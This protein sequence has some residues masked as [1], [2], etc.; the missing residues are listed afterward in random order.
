MKYYKMYMNRQH[1][2]DALHRRLLELKPPAAAPARRRRWPQAAVLAACCVLVMGVGVWRLLPVGEEIPPNAVQSPAPSTPISG[3]ENAADFHG[4]V[5]DSG[6]KVD[7]SMFVAIPAIA[8]PEASSEWDTARDI[9]APEGS[10][11][12]DLTEEDIS[13]ILWNGTVPEGAGNVPWMLFWDGYTISGR[14]WYDG[15]GALWQV[16]LWGTEG[17]NGSFS[18]ALAPETLPPT[19]TVYEGEETTEV[20]GVEVSGWSKRYDRDGDGAAETVYESAFLN[21][22]VGVRASFVSREDSLMSDLFIRWALSGDGGLSIEHLMTAEDVPDF[23]SADFASLEAARQETA[24]APYLPQEDFDG[25]MEFYGH[26]TYQEGIQHQ[27]YARWSWWDLREVSLWVNRPEG[28]GVPKDAVVD[29]RDAAAYDV[30]RYEYP[31]ADTVP[32]R[33]WDTMDCPA[34]RAEDMSRE[35]VAARKQASDTSGSRFVFQV[36]YPDG[37]WVEYRCN[38]LTVEEMWALVAET[39]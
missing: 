20:N 5:A 11:T 30:R 13:R 37:T 4:F 34:F 36:V 18:I 6:R 7:A 33:Y 17:K 27:L 31:W 24:F 29:V 2:S 25:Y 32:E 10:F 28:G 9:A 26:L 23:R 38:G 35:V 22:G 14:A 21:R 15:A 12:V 39:L 1:V 16:E 19:C 8:Y 3:D